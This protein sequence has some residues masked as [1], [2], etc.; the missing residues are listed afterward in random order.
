MAM[1]TP[2]ETP[3]KV[4]FHGDSVLQGLLSKIGPGAR[5]TFAETTGKRGLQT[6]I[7]PLFGKHSM[8]Q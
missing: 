2:M 4:D 7:V 8:R 6:S 5:V 1:Q 3:L